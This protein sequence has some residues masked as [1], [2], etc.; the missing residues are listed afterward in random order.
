MSELVRAVMRR[1]DLGTNEGVAHNRADPVRT[2]HQPAYRRDGSKEEMPVWT[3]GTPMPEIGGDRLA[4]VGGQWQET[5]PSALATHT[6]LSAVPIDVVQRQPD[7]LA[8]S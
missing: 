1:V 7:D 8:G 6:Q 5:L 4:H 2:F 3:R